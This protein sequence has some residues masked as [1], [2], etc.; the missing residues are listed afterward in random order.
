MLENF[1][2]KIKK[3][4]EVLYH[5]SANK[6]IGILEPR[7]I[8]TRDE[9]DGK[10]VF[11]TPDFKFALMF[12]NREADDRWTAKGIMNGRYYYLISDKERFLE[13]DNGGAVYYLKPDTFSTDLNKGMR[14]KEWVSK[15]KVEPFKKDVVESSLDLMAE[16]GIEIYFV[17]M[18][19]IN[20]FR[21]KSVSE[22]E[23]FLDSLS[24]FRYKK[25]TT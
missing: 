11:G 12:L 9:D 18:E 1:E 23:K 22:K 15:E 20:E 8:K 16:K 21:Q 25:I 3:K 6:E 4:P 13:S 10:V 2:N 24:E 7:A 19:K 17:D 5:A 14:E